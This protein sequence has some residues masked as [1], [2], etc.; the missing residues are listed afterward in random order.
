MIQVV[1]DFLAAHPE[2][3]G[4]DDLR[5]VIRDALGNEVRPDPTSLYRVLYRLRKK[6]EIQET[7]GKV[8]ARRLARRTVGHDD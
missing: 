4:Q 7:G 3:V 8:R 1:R 6:G 5:E 2:G